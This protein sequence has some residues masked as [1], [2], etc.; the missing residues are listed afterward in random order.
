[1]HRVADGSYLLKATL[2]TM[3]FSL[4]LVSQH[5]KKSIAG[6]RRDV[7]PIVYILNPLGASS[8]TYSAIRRPG[9]TR[10]N[11]GQRPAI[12]SKNLCNCFT[13]WTRVKFT[14]INWPIR[15][16]FGSCWAAGKVLVF[17]LDGA[18]LSVSQNATRA[19]NLL[20]CRSPRRS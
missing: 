15:S 19:V 9:F 7:K 12:V 20:Y 11:L 1:M 4:Q 5:R 13:R 16:S 10:S 8:Q 6:W 14:W 18:P 17:S 3:Q 2:S